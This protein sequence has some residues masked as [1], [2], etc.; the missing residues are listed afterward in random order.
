MAFLF[1]SSSF[2]GHTYIHT[3]IH[4]Y[5]DTQTHWYLRPY[6]PTQHMPPHPYVQTYTQTRPGQVLYP[7]SPTPPI[8]TGATDRFFL[9][10]ICV[11][12]WSSSP[13]CA[14]LAMNLVRMGRDRPASCLNILVLGDV[15]N[16]TCKAGVRSAVSLVFGS[17]VFSQSWHWCYATRAGNY[18]SMHSTQTW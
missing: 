16:Q 2:Q 9:V 14:G 11:L 8:M 1:I 7:T 17:A 13:V 3:N 5:L 12:V 10:S 18:L 6:M 4:T 15:Q